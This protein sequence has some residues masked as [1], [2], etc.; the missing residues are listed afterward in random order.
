MKLLWIR[1]LNVLPRNFTT[2]CFVIPYSRQEAGR[3]GTEQ[4]SSQTYFP[5]SGSPL[6]RDALGGVMDH[7][8]WHS[9]PYDKRRVAPLSCEKRLPV[10]AGPLVDS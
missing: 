3:S 2:S 4:T 7:R 10:D 8:W 6:L 5:N 9:V 1:K